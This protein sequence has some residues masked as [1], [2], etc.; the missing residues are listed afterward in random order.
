MHAVDLP[1]APLFEP[2]ARIYGEPLESLPQDDQHDYY[3]CG[4]DTMIDEVTG[5][6]ESRGVPISRIHRE[7]FFN[8]SYV[9]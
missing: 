7:C 5:W 1:P 2:V 6:L 4:L 8:A 3:L 9:R